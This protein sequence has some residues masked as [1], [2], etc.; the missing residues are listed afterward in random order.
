[1]SD[2]ENTQP[3]P[4]TTPALDQWSGRDDGP[5]PEFNRW[6]KVIQPIDSAAPSERPGAA[7]IGFVSEEGARRNNCRGGAIE[8]P[9]ALRGK[10]ANIPVHDEL[11]RYDAGDV[12]IEGSDMEGVQRR[13]AD[14]V[15]SLISAGH[16]PVV[17][18]GS[19]EVGYASYLGLRKALGKPVSIVN[20]DGHLDVRQTDIAT[21]G[22]PFTQVAELEGE[23]F[24][25]AVIGAS[26]ADNTTR[27]FD[28]A[29]ELGTT[30]VR[31]TEIHAMTPQ[32]AAERA[33]EVEG[34]HEDLYLTIDL[35]A[36]SPAVAP[37]V[38]SP[39]TAGISAESTLAICRALAGTGRLKL[40]DVAELNPRF[41]VDGRTANFAARLLNDVVI[42]HAKAT[43]LL[44]G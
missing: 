33:L 22:T 37:G 35:D 4:L 12:V 20:L 8:G 11:P 28:F 16:L 25:Y 7:I 13:L 41:D 19:H 14:A 27:L 17:L 40:V 38:S 23:E 36:I 5:G 26:E 21:H 9:K 30:V 15:A 39:C 3:Y 44:A 2:T 24:D 10:L 42:A 6:H 34:R 43:G 18:G 1:M 32:Q 31:D 29:A